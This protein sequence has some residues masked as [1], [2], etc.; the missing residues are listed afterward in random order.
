[1]EKPTK[2]RMP[3]HLKELRRVMNQL[4]TPEEI[5]AAQREVDRLKKAFDL[6]AD[7]NDWK[8][9]ICAVVLPE[10]F[11]KVMLSADD[12]ISAIWFYMGTKPI[13]TQLNVPKGAVL[14]QANRRL[15]FKP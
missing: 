2:L 5:D 11:A 8:A 7:P 9:P 10:A 4:R 3:E 15:D 13:V 1:M 6:V 14:F 12:V